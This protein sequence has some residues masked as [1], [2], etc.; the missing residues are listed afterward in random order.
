MAEI[1]IKKKILIVDDERDLANLFT[2]T[3]E[4]EGFNVRYCDQGDAALQTAREFRPDFILLDLMMPGLSGF[5][6]LELFRNMMETSTA[7]IVIFSAL[8]NPADIQRAKKIGAD[9][10]LVKSNTPFQ[11]VIDRIKE[12][13]NQPSEEMVT[14]SGELKI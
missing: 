7:K 1:I 10:Y 3:L 2:T 14:S 8:D 12:L 11:A 9:D 6:T 5:D 4:T 13:I